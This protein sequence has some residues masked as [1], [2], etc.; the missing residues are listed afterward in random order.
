[1]IIALAAAAAILI[2]VNVVSI[3]I[4]GWRMAPSGEPAPPVQ[5]RPPVSI[6]VPACGIEA[7]TPETLVRAFSLDW[8]DYE[9]DLLRRQ[10]PRSCHWRDT[11][12]DGC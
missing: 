10:S 12:G 7:F 9:A 4:A 8:P 1:M 11:P 2:L 5:K 6:V 3:I